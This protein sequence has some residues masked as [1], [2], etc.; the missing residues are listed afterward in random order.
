MSTPPSS[1]T[2]ADVS[3]ALRRVDAPELE[4]YLPLSE[5][6]LM[7]VGD[8][9]NDVFVL[10]PPQGKARDDRDTDRLVV[11][12]GTYSEPR[13]LRAGV[14]AYQLLAEFT[15]LPVPEVVAFDQGDDQT[16][17]FVAMEH[18]PGA[19]LAGGFPDTERATDPAA[20]RLLG[21]VMA[22]FGSIPARATDGY[23]YIQ[24]TDYRDG[25]P[26]AVGEY[27]DC[28]SWL[29]EYGTELYDAAADHESLNAIVPDVLE[30]LRANRNR[31]PEAPSPSVIITDFSPANLMS[32][33]GTPPNSVD[34]LTGVID[35]ER[36][37]IG[38]LEFAAVNAEYLLTRYVDD[39]APIRDAL[40]DPLPF[41]PGVPKRDFYRVLAMGRSVAALPFWYDSEDEMYEQRARE[42]ASE[43]ERIVR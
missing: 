36:A 5:A 3:Q 12:F 43:L 28:S 23:G 14:T 40:Y 6:S 7:H 25:S 41:G 30:F 18:R 8:G 38:P 9:F 19:A 11:K 33:D 1:L 34:E 29:V 10:S 26:V 21:A 35:L 4:G 16:P 31:L 39:P 27:D 32:R 20:V 13:H 22:A 37:K 17:P 15:D 42:I 2:R 24:R